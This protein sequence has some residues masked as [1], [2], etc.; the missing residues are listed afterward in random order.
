MKNL[1]QSYNS[2]VMITKTNLGM[3]LQAD[4][5][6]WLGKPENPTLVKILLGIKNLK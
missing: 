5:A 4:K 2:P 1:F 6:L 3:F